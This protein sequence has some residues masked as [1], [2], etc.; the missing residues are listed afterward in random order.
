MRILARS[1]FKVLT[2]RNAH[3]NNNPA[4]A[5]RAQ[6][7]KLR[8]SILGQ[9]DIGSQ[10]AIY[11]SPTKIDLLNRFVNRE[12]IDQLHRPHRIVF[13]FAGGVG[14]MGDLREEIQR[15]PQNSHHVSFV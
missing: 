12:A 8:F 11:G 7:N 1:W 14:H 15:P 3:A 6:L 9:P 4:K 13:Q 10:Q 2:V 5:P